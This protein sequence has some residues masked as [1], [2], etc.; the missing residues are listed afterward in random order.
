MKKLCLLFWI[1]LALSR[2]AAGQDK[3]PQIVLPVIN[4]TSRGMIHGAIDSAFVKTFPK[5]VNLPWFKLNKKFLEQFIAHD[6]DRDNSFKK[7]GSIKYSISY[8]NE[9]DL[10]GNM[11]SLIYMAYDSYEITN[12]ARILRGGEELWIVNLEGACAVVLVFVQ[13]GDLSEV[14]RIFKSP[15]NDKTAN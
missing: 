8:T 12:G 9:E 7:S 3:R 10:P 4:I 5:D 11:V 6:I 15:K 2:S 13:D 1:V 14:H